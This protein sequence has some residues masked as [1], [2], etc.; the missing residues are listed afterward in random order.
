VASEAA[1]IEACPLGVLLHY[2]SY[3]CGRQ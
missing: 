2:Q 3:R 1:G